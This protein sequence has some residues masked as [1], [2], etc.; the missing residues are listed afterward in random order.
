MRV[1]VED[2]LDWREKKKVGRQNGSMC[3]LTDE[4]IS[5]DTRYKEKRR[6][7]MI[8]NFKKY[9]L[10]ITNRIS[11]KLFFSILKSNFHD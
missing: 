3:C 6:V 11:F 5:G 8:I 1:Q 10:I 4:E 9:L 2:L 7:M